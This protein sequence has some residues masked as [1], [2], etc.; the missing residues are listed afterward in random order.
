MLRS[1]L[2]VCL[3]V[4]GI[5]TVMLLAACGVNNP[6][7]GKYAISGYESVYALQEVDTAQY[8]NYTDNP[9]QSVEKTPVST[10]GLDMD[11]GSYA[12][13]RRFISHGEV[14]PPDAVRVEEFINYFPPASKESL[15]QLKNS[16]FNA[17]YEVTTSPWDSNK[18][19]LRVNVKADDLKTTEI[20]PANLVFLVDISGSM[21]G[22]ERLDL[23]KSSL[24]LLVKELRP[25]DKVSLVT[26]ADGTEIVLE[27][28]SGKEKAKI[29]NAL[30]KLSTGGATAGGEGLKLAYQMAEQGKI[31]N[32]VNRI[33]LATDGDFNVG[34]SNVEELKSFVSRARDKG[35]TLSTLGF[36]DN[37]YN[38]AMMVQ[39]ANVGNGNYSYIDSL[40]EAQKV[41]QEEMR[42]TL[43]TV[44]KDA[45]AQIEF[46]KDQVLEYRQLGYEKRQLAAEDF[47]NDNIDAGDIG[48]G[49][50]VTVLYEL[51][52]VGGKASVDAL[53]YQKK[54]QMKSNDYDNELAYLKLRWKMPNGESSQL[55]SLPIEKKAPVSQFDKA[56]IETRFVS[57]VAAFGQKL[58][59]NP[60]LAKT[61]YEQIAQWANNAK[62]EDPNGYRGE[63][64]KLVKLTGS[65]TR[66]Q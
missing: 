50:R 51:T 59:N 14:P 30:D 18:V 63:F 39:I 34:I 6:N 57:A 5:C 22:P 28:T 49:K 56:S 26:Y 31:D 35:I 10:F 40:S 4:T 8:K 45:K 21:L 11:T 36:G 41:L 32:G 1:K 42:A 3:S 20:P 44:A 17:S 46:N 48:A 12:N 25:E 64:V 33:L 54:E 38:E 19:L 9:I 47:N 2:K 62:G 55:V 66:S 37:N 60:A 15:K 43:V 24:K 53:R 29:I 65:L 13:V 23:L 52:L 27:P 16:P 58:R 7:M 61:S